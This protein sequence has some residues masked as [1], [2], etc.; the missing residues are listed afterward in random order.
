MANHKKNKPTVLYID[1]DV[2][3]LTS[4]KY[5]F[6]DYYNITIVETAK[7]G[8]NTLRDT[9]FDVIVADQRMP[10]MTGTEFFEKMIGDYPEP[11]RIILTGFSDIE[12]VID[13]INKGRI[14]YYLK[15]PW[16]EEEIRMVLDN[17]IETVHLGKE[18]SKLIEELKLAN[19]E[20]LEYRDKLEKKVEE[21][22]RELYEK[23]EELEKYTKL[24]EG[25]EFKIKELKMKISDLE[26]QNKNLQTTK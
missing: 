9:E 16:K 18:N 25:R 3:N 20:L 23:N 8:I 26:N 15:K 12:A 21:R 4:F 14:Y 17:A 1:D 7:N 5:Q 22:T 10:E 6:Q 24:F 13:G 2:Q 11:A 19:E